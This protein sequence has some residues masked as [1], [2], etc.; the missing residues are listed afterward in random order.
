M[1][2]QPS[3]YIL[4]IIA[5][6]LLAVPKQS[7]GFSLA[8]DS[9]AEWGRFPK[10]CV[11][12][13]RWG[14]KFFNSYDTAY[15]DGTGYKFNIKLKTETWN[16]QYLFNLP[17]NYR[18]E[19]FSDWNT[20][21]GFWLSYLAVSVGY[22]LNVSKYF[23]GS[24][25]ARKRFNFKFNCALFGA[26]FYWITN[27]VGS[28]IK[29]FGPKNDMQ[30][31]NIPF[32]GINNTVFGVD[33]YYILNNKK[34]S[35]AAAFN[36]SKIQKRSQGSFFFGLSYWRQ[37]FEFDFNRLP[38]DIIKDLPQ[39]WED[40]GYIYYTDNHNY[41]IKAGYGYNWVFAHKW[42]LGVSESPMFGIKRG[43]IND[44]NEIKTYCS[45]SNRL[46]LS[47]VWNSRPWFA[48]IIATA[49]NTLVYD[50]NHQLMTGIYNIEVSAGFRFN[51]W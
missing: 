27:D 49:D 14:D 10:F 39:S 7:H 29:E 1:K 26:D 24:D 13:Y 42:L 6:L 21:A 16:D 51:L 23:G 46:Q 20:S 22:D 12:T 50:R 18:M 9:I 19:M 34:Y 36:F 15:V 35:R 5:T 17:D 3:K 40:N 33:T 47:I 44:Y 37:K 11:D 2:L 48:G 25:K 31:L 45:L 4:I 32:D 38:Q 30:K 28:N 43:Y 41:S 8:L